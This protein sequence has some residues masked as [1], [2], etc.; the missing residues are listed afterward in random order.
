MGIA[1]LIWHCVS[2]IPCRD[3]QNVTGNK[4]PLPSGNCHLFSVVPA[5][6]RDI[7]QLGRYLGFLGFISDQSC[8]QSLVSKDEKHY[9]VWWTIARSGEYP[10]GK[11][12]LTEHV[13]WDIYP[14]WCAHHVE[15]WGWISLLHCC[16]EGRAAH[17]IPGLHLPRR[18]QEHS[19]V[20]SPHPSAHVPQQVASCCAPQCRTRAGQ[21]GYDCR[22]FVVPLLYS[23]LILT[24]LV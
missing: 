8:A 20:R 23:L 12:V 5:C 4:E 10:P 1:F 21:V 16:M 3:M 24:F 7:T 11:L 15:L 19:A 13:A 9:I 17:G 6:V 18:A 2:P 22:M 14:A